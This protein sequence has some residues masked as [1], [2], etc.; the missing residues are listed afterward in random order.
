[1]DEAWLVDAA[2]WAAVEPYR[3]APGA[4]VADTGTVRWFRTPVA[5]EGLNGIL[6]AGLDGQDLDAS[7]GQ[8]LAPFRE[9]GVPM[10]WH[11][12]PT[13]SPPS[14]P[15]ALEAA[16][17]AH[18]EDEPGMVAD[19]A[20]L[21]PPSSAPAGLEV[22]RVGDED[23][24]AAW[25]CVWAGLP[26]GAD[27]ASL[28]EVR[29]PKALATDPPVPHLLAVLDGTPV[30]CAAVLVGDGRGGRPP[31]AWLED[32][33]TT[34]AVRRRGIG[35]AV[36]RACLDLARSHG[37]DRAALTASVDGHRIYRRLGFRERCRVVRY[38]YPPAG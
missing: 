14:L 32:V 4:V 11:L 17:L 15:R 38:R 30:G 34:A 20:A 10:Q 25:C 23:G 7:V 36:T 1:M 2:A 37:L 28:V 24:L 18:Q 26:P 27:A 31:A 3:A 12:G 13:T 8:A 21:G 35:T 29:A 22:L 33:V 16:G 5:Y 19:L 6:W 9:T